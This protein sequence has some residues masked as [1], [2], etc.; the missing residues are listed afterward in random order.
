VRQ[1]GTESKGK[2]SMGQRVEESKSCESMSRRLKGQGL[3]SCNMFQ[4]RAACTERRRSRVEMEF[5]LDSA[6]T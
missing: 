2:E 5:V 6:R 4:H 3:K 1:K